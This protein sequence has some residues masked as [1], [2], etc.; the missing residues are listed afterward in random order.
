MSNHTQDDYPDYVLAEMRC[1]ALRAQLLHNDILAIS[2]ALKA[3]LIDAD[4]AIE[5][6]WNC[7]AL[8]LVAPS[9]AITAAST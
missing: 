1:A 7:D 6:L 2:L 9:S 5:H 8:R 4:C 3:K